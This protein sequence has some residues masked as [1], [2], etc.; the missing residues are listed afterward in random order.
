MNAIEQC[1]LDI[2]LIT[3]LYIRDTSSLNS[4]QV[5]AACEVNGTVQIYVFLYCS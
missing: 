2:V 4:L 5:L 1:V 3:L